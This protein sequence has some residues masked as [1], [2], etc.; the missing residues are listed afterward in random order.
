[1]LLMWCGIMYLVG[2]AVDLE[3]GQLALVVP[4]DLVAWGVLE[5]ALEPV[6]LQGLALLDVLE[7]ELADEQTVLDSKETG[8]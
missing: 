5:V 3:D 4:V 8:A 6:P 2:L 7:A 1:M